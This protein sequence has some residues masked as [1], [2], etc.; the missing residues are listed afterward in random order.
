MSHT[1]FVS[2]PIIAGFLYVEQ[3]IINFYTYKFNAFFC[4]TRYANCNKFL[5]LNLKDSCSMLKSRSDFIKSPSC[6][7]VHISY[8]EKWFTIKI[9]T[10][11][12]CQVGWLVPN[13]PC[14]AGCGTGCG[15]SFT[16][17]K[18]T[19]LPKFDRYKR[20]TIVRNI[21]ITVWW[22]TDSTGAEDI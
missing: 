18:C 22:R 5:K 13:V 14:A 7:P 6:M 4:Q 19:V 20:T 8:P 16:N 10:W 9:H 17:T 15:C 21:E 3:P 1:M 11:I 12:N 2:F